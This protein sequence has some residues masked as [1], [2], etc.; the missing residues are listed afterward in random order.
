MHVKRIY[1]KGLANFDTLTDVEKKVFLVMDFQVSY[2]ME[3]FTHHFAS[4]RN[5]DI[6]A[7]RDFL[8]QVGAPNLKPIDEMIQLINEKVPDWDPDNVDC[9]FCEVVD[10]DED[11][12]DR[13]FEKDPE[14]E[15]AIE[16]WGREFYGQ[17]QEMWDAIA[18]YLERSHGITLES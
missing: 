3:G 11:D 9:F 18:R 6:P 8:R 2:E 12:E 15:H 1:E 13:L 10:G 17:I 4:H 14:I 16:K 7:I 5:K